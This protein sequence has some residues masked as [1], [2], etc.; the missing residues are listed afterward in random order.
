MKTG[1]VREGGIGCE[2]LV[3]AEW[4]RDGCPGLSS[5]SSPPP[6]LPQG[7]TGAVCAAEGAHQVRTVHTQLAALNRHGE[8]AAGPGWVHLPHVVWVAVTS[9]AG[10]LRTSDSLPHTDNR[11]HQHVD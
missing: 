5:S 2:T 3:T 10:S 4:D 7:E 1:L 9:R 11:Y 6:S 8:R